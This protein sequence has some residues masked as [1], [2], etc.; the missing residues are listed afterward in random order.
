MAHPLGNSPSVQ[1]RR[2]DQVAAALDDFFAGSGRRAHAHGAG[3]VQLWRELHASTTGGKLVRP[4]LVMRA[5]EGLGG[6]AETSVARVAAAFELLH[7]ALIVHDDVID[8]DFVRRGKPNIPGK[9]R[10]L[11]LSNGADAATADHHGLSAAVVAGDL[12]LFYSYRMIDHASLPEDTRRQL[13]DL[14]DEALFASAAGELLD[15]DYSGAVTIPTV[16]SILEMARLKT[17]VYSFE[18]PLKVGAVLAGSS[19]ETIEALGDFGREIGTAYQIVD[20]LLGVFG[21][22]IATGKSTTSDLREGKRTVL[23]A[24]AVTSELWNQIDGL[25]GSATLSDREADELREVFDASGARA[26][27]EKLLAEYVG[28]AEAIL[29]QP[30]IPSALREELQPMIADALG[31]HR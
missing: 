11:A 23:V 24:H 17:A 10:D 20:D 29:D 22:P 25:F 16:D 9:Y 31:R 14:M 2:A 18:V 3:Y 26:F 1:R 12:A 5:Y 6:S 13:L 21:D 28:R 30:M 8:R 15:L 7:T 19:A 4:Q 27:A